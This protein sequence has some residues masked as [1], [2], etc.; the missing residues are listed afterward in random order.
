ML[1]WVTSM[2]FLCISLGHF[3]YRKRRWLRLR[4]RRCQEARTIVDETICGYD[5]LLHK[6]KVRV[7]LGRRLPDL[8]FTRLSSAAFQR[9]SSYE[10]SS[11]WLE[12][13]GK[14][15]KFWNHRNF[16]IQWKTLT[17]VRRRRHKKPFQSRL[18][19]RKTFFSCWDEKRNVSFL[20]QP[21]PR[22]RFR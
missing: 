9:I 17:F 10:E 5:Y 15:R 8:W 4:I 14:S 1:I 12:R 3:R 21:R 19:G 7:L 11:P 6:E 13:A 16:W 22:Q 18:Y 20:R 2:R